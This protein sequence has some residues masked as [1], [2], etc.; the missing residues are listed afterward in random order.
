MRSAMLCRAVVFW[1]GVAAVAAVSPAVAQAP[2]YPPPPLSAVPGPPASPEATEIATCLCLGQAVAALSA[3]MSAKQR[4][5]AA[6]RDEVARLDAR[7]ERE[8]AGMDVNDPQSVAR[9]RQMLEQRDAAYR[10]ST[11]LVTGDLSSVIER[12]NSR[13]NEYNARC[14]NRPRDP[15]LLGRVQERLS[16]PPLY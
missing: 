7:L 4:S 12:Y 14:A 10:R 16:C 9:F 2:P 6:V 8:R 13:I 1:A 5:Y 11:G 15:E 3:D